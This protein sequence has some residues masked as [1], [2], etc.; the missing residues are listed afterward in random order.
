MTWQA[1]FVQPCYQTTSL[2][3]AASMGGIAGIIVKMAPDAVDGG[4][5]LYIAM[6]RARRLDQGYRAAVGMDQASTFGKQAAPS[7][8]LVLGVPRKAVLSSRASYGGAAGVVDGDSPLGGVEQVGA[9]VEIA[10]FHRL[11]LRYD[12]LL[13]SVASNLRLRPYRWGR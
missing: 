12:R 8:P 1:V 9:R 3:S 11:K 2:Y 5:D 4:R 13:S 7:G 6:E 10:W